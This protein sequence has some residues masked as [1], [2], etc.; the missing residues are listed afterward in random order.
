MFSNQLLLLQ[1][2]RCMDFS[3]LQSSD[4]FLLLL[5]LA[6]RGEGGIFALASFMRCF[7]ELLTKLTL[8]TLLRIDLLHPF[9]IYLRGTLK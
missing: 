6:K 5:L 1:V 8:F 4:G 2:I 3:H 9:V 7:E